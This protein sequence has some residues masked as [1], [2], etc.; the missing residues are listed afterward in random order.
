MRPRM[1]GWVQW[2]NFM[3]EATSRVQLL[4]F[5]GARE[6]QSYTSIDSSI[7]PCIHEFMHAC[8]HLSIHPTNSIGIYGMLEFIRPSKGIKMDR[9]HWCWLISTYYCSFKLTAGENEG[10]SFEHAVVAPSPM[11]FLVKVRSRTQTGWRRAPDLVP[12]FSVPW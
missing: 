2:E 12:T 6:G 8:I 4:L 11:G 9:N 7:H 5:P 1:E 3:H 10:S